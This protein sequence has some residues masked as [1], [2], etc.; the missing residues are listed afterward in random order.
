V[1]S[2]IL[3]A[4]KNRDKL[5]EI[6]N[7]FQDSTYNFVTLN[8][9][10]TI[11]EPEENG[12]TFEEN[13]IIKAKYYWHHIH[14]PVISDDSGLVV[15]ALNGEP[16]IF[17]AR[18]ASE[19]SNYRAN[20]EKLL[21]KMSNLKGSARKAHFI[22]HAVYQDSEALISQE[23]KIDG[24]ITNLPRGKSGFGYD[25]IFLIPELGKTFAELP[26]S[27]KN[28]I[29]HR[30]RAFTKLHEQLKSFHNKS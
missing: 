1:H 15:P 23:G 5:V 13:A 9:F 24:I 26:Q 4:T 28:K 20:N 25:P 29:S 19:N 3:L 16:G 27:E 8:D 21:T 17:S 6:L 10:P 11:E 2:S 22:C 14:I 12:M 18:Y 7:I 30:F